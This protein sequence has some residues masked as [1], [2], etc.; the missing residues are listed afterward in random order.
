MEKFA[1]LLTWVA[2]TQRKKSRPKKTLIMLKDKIEAAEG[3]VE[4]IVPGSKAAACS[5]HPAEPRSLG[6]QRGAIATPKPRTPN[7][8]QVDSKRRQS[9]RNHKEVITAQSRRREPN[10]LNRLQAPNSRSKV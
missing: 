3:Q 7:K 2:I 1:I 8:S 9:R 4:E 10:K 5:T 6:L